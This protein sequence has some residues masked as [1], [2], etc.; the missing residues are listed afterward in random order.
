MGT[1][2]ITSYFDV[3]QIVLYAFWIFF[4]GL[5]MYLHRENKR[6]GYPLESDRSA[7]APR[8]PIVGFPDLPAPK[9]FRLAGGRTVSVPCAETDD[10]E[11]K[12][13]PAAAHPGAPLVPTG[14]PMV[15]AVGPAAYALR[16]DKPE[17]ADD[18]KPS[19]VPMRSVPGFSIDEGDP[20][21]V[22][23]PVIA[24]DGARAGVVAEV[25]ID[26]AEPQI[27]YFEVAIP[28]GVK[29]LL[30]IHYTVLDRARGQLDVQAI[31]ASQ[32]A[33]VPTIAAADRIT[34]REEDRITAYYAGGKLYATA[35]RSEPLL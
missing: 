31:L 28:S 15:D 1:G 2:A 7:R 24:A 19:I 27:R 17:L 25:W 10:R 11:I 23:M 21:P 13:K 29:V 26:R 9:T 32:F 20:D 5:I 14:N 33:D 6:E 3:A 22:G 35:A 16:E 12:A 30:P 8:V 18:G 4:A 34:K